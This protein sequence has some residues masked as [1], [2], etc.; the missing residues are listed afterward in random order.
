MQVAYNEK[1][2]LFATAMSVN[3]HRSTRRLIPEKLNLNEDRNEN[4]KYHVFIGN[5]A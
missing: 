3:I 5:F 4:L 1:L 2:L